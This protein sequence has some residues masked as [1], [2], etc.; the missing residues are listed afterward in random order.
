MDEIDGA[1]ESES[2][3]AVN[4]LLDYIYHGKKAKKNP[5][6]KL[7]KDK[8]KDKDDPEADTQELFIKR[9]VIFICNDPYA[10]GLREL[11]KKAWVYYFKPPE[12]T[13][14]MQ[15]LK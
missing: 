12:D 10:K 15:R 5:K 14:I 9:P 3:G 13:Q 6:K 2:D 4:K 11:R 8:D 7:F 1:L